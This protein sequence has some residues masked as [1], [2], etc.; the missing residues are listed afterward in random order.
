[1]RKYF[2]SDLHLDVSRPDATNAFLD[3]LESESLAGQSLYILGDLFEYWVDD[4]DINPEFRRVTEALRRFTASGSRCFLMHGNRDFMLGPQFMAESGAVLLHDP[5]L[6]SIGGQSVLISHGDIY[7]TD[8]TAYQRYRRI[9]R[10][11]WAQRIY[12]ALPMALKQKVAA[13]IRGTSK[14]GYGTK[15]PDIL[16][17]NQGAIEQALREYQVDTMIHGHTHRPAIHRFET[18]WTERHPDRAGR[19]V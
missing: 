9:V 5:T 4:S 6:I 15:R 13:R 17:V 12:N 10:S 14:A 1:M 3:F 7:C 8:D 2:V 16:D 11:P 18:G 19:L